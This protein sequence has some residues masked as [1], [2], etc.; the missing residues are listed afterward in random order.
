MIFRA[1]SWSLPFWAWIL[2]FLGIL[3]VGVIGGLLISRKIMTKYL[4]DNPPINENMIR[5]MYRQMG[6][7]P[8]EKQ[9]RQVM[10]AVN[11]QT[12]AKK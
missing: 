3:I 7:T 6:K 5:I 12:G 2:I 11:S 8:S 1:A 10:A 9:V 4:Q